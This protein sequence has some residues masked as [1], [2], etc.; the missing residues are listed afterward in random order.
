MNHLFFEILFEAREFILLRLSGVFVLNNGGTKSF[1]CGDL[2]FDVTYHVVYEV[3]LLTA[4]FDPLS[5]T[6]LK[7]DGLGFCPLIVYYDVRYL[8]AKCQ[9]RSLLTSHIFKRCREFTHLLLEVCIDINRGRLLVFL[10]NDKPV[11]NFGDLILDQLNEVSEVRVFDVFYVELIRVECLVD[12][13]GGSV[14]A[15]AVDAV[16][17]EEK[18]A[19]VVF[20]FLLAFCLLRLKLSFLFR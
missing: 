3:C 17:F 6:L 14:D 5:S 20:A 13:V 19:Q 12:Q 16:R 11:L 7:L 4:L 2:L 1:Q 8:I 18:T 10:R 9:K 15:E